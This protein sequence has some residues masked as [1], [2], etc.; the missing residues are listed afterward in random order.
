MRMITCFTFLDTKNMYS[1]EI[2]NAQIG[3]AH[4]MPLRIAICQQ[5]IHTVTKTTNS[6]TTKENKIHWRCNCLRK[7]GWYTTVHLF[8]G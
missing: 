2:F 6:H 4:K 8:P 1:I 7:P 3:V 5:I